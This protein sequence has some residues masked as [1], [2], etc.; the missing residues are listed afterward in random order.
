MKISDFRILS[1]WIGKYNPALSKSDSSWDNSHGV[2]LVIIPL[3]VKIG[4]LHYLVIEDNFFC[5][6]CNIFVSDFLLY[7]DRYCKDVEVSSRKM[8]R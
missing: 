3:T 5:W 6:Q 7:D 4:E 8:C 1:G 2:R